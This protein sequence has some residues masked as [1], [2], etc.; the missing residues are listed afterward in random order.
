MK[1]TEEAGESWRHP[2]LVERAGE[3][4]YVARREAAP[5]R[6]FSVLAGLFV[7]GKACWAF[8]P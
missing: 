4:A 7:G 1:L 5:E 8:D 3:T 6:S 2:T